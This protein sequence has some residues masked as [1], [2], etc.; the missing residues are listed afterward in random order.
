MS[1]VRG[2]FLEVASGTDRALAE[3]LGRS[4]VVWRAGD[5]HFDDGS[6]FLLFDRGNAVRLVGVVNRGAFEDIR[7]SVVEVAMASDAF[8]GALELW[9]RSFMQELGRR[10]GDKK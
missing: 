2:E 9:S 6:L 4:G 10:T 5:E 7:N 3:A 1:Y 8:Y